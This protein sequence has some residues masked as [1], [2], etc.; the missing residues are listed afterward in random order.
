MSPFFPSED[1]PNLV[2]RVPN[3]SLPAKAVNEAHQLPLLHTIV[4]FRFL[5]FFS[6]PLVLAGLQQFSTPP[7][8]LATRS[9]MDSAGF[10]S[11]QNAVLDNARRTRSTPV[12]VHVRRDAPVSP[13]IPAAQCTTSAQWAHVEQKPKIHVW[14]SCIK[15]ITTGPLAYLH[16]FMPTALPLSFLLSFQWLS[17]KFHAEWER[18]QR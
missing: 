1:R 16:Q 10:G 8:A 7:V 11:R 18:Y 12:T 17:K 15:P 6:H 4:A 14:W 9:P 3:I 13:P 5:L 2:D